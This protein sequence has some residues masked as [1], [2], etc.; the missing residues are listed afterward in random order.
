M[1]IEEHTEDMLERIRKAE[2]SI[3]AIIIINDITN[4]SVRYMSKRGHENL[5]VS[6]DDLQRMGTEYHDR[7]FNPEDAKD[8]VPKILGLLERNNDD[9]ILSFFQQVRR[10]PEHNWEWYLTSVKIFQRNEQGKPVSTICTAIP[11]D[12]QHHIA[13]KAQRLLEENNFLRANLHVFNTLTKREK[14]ILGLMAKGLSSAIMANQLSIS[15][16]TAATHRKN[17]KRKLSAET[18]YDIT[19]FAHAF[20]VI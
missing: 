20:N 3:P 12:A 19:R 18:T 2:D 1:S 13:K 15:E 17:I 7:F 10:S 11:V 4:G 16:K 9:E 6:L 8:Y 14:E 5:G